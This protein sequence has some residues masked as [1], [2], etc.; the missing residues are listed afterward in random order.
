MV[1]LLEL[2]FVAPLEVVSYH[3]EGVKIHMGENGTGYALK[4]RKITC[5]CD[6]HHSQVQIYKDLCAW[7]ICANFL[8]QIKSRFYN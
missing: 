8:F 3:L 6:L 2:C 4:H 7:I 5:V 1:I